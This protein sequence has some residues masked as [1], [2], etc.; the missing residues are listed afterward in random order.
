MSA[1]RAV[2]LGA[3][4]LMTAAMCGLPG[5]ASAEPVDSWWFTALH[6]ADAHQQTTGKGVTI[7]M[8]DT[9]LDTSIPD[10][11]GAD[12]EF[13]KACDVDKKSIPRLHD[14]VANHGT[15]MTT[16]IVGQGTGNA[17]GGRGVMGVAPGATIRFY[18]DEPDA[19]LGTKDCDEVD[20]V[21]LFAQAIRDKVDIISFS[22]TSSFDLD[23]VVQRAIDAGIVVVAGAG[24]PNERIS[25][26]ASIAGVVAV[27][28]ADR[29][30]R[31]WKDNPHVSGSG[32]EFGFPVITAPGVDVPVGAMDA[33]GGWHSGVSRTGTSD[34]TALVSGLLALVKSRY[35][36]A[37]GR[38]LVQH[39]IHHPASEKP[40]SYNDTYGFGIAS[41]TTMLKHDPTSWPDVNPLLNGPERAVTDFPQDGADRTTKVPAPTED[42]AS[43]QAATAED[44]AGFAVWWWA[45]GAVV[46][47]GVVAAVV[48]AR[49]RAMRG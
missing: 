3:A 17:P 9:G 2:A 26:P 8:I 31:P 20:T 7:A 42:E 39:L 14:P 22:T 23:V 35:P 41:A 43:G 46:L 18:D 24:K 27:M 30:G 45:I 16:I 38:Q 37:T 32:T 10:L 5:A 34:S 47:V 48:V 1:R 12:I 33:A 40:I 29:A 36:Q 21:D 6:L 25:S 4:T 15:A 19:R 49:R 44:S 13:G 28:S 11:K